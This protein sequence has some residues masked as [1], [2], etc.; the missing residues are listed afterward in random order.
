MALRSAAVAAVDLGA[1]SGRVL[2][3]T[4]VEGRLEL[5]QVARFANGGRE[6]NGVFSWDL[7]ALVVEIERGLGAATKAA[8]ARGLLLESLGVD[9]WAVDYGLVDASG[10]LLRLP[11]H[12]RDSR[13]NASFAAVTSQLDPWALY[14]RNGI[15]LLAFNTLFQLVA[16]GDLTDSARNMLLIPDL[17]NFMFCGVKAWEITNASTTQLLTLDREW[18]DDLFTRFGLPRELVGE[19]VDPG[20]VLGH[21]VSPTAL[22]AGVS[23][24]TKIITVASHDTASAVLAVPAEGS[25]FAYVSSGTWSLVGVE[26]DDP[27]LDHDAFEAGY[28]NELGAFG[29][30]RY[31]RN[32]M[33]FWLLQEVIREFALDGQ[34]LD[35]AMLTEQARSLSPRR[36]LVDAESDELLGAGDMR[37]RLTAQ[38]ERLGTEIPVSPA[39]FTRCILDSL[40][41]AYRRAIRG[42]STV[43][44]VRVDAIYIVGGGA[45]NAELCQLTADA[46]AVPV[47][48]GPVEAAAIG[49]ALM[50]LCGLGVLAQDLTALRRL[51]DSSFPGTLFSPLVDASEWDEAQ[52]LVETRAR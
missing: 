35:A 13:T 41:L 33:G 9:S 46:C 37:G 32:V 12:H 5:E 26:L 45:L 19:L 4:L 47:H 25:N 52:T 23:G 10:R 36:F 50:Q 29:R 28:T 44:G 27:L 42:I 38:C 20:V 31:L 11:A 3:V 51:V 7:P 24:T 22:A 6:V 8:R 34:E 18:D 17:I 14:Q 39:E 2:L 48:A 49:N 15:A 43:T 16:D 21:V 1:S 30:T 40:A